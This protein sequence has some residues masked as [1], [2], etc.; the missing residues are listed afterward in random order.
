MF[1]ITFLLIA[2]EVFD[3][4]L[5]DFRLINGMEYRDSGFWDWGAWERGEALAAA[6]AW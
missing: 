5:S 4:R 6:E 2:M 3:F 1:G